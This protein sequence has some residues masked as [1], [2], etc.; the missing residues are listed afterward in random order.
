MINV[1]NGLARCHE[2]G[3]ASFTVAEMMRT[4]DF[5]LSTGYKE[6]DTVANGRLYYQESLKYYLMPMVVYKNSY[7]YACSNVEDQVLL[8]I[9]A[10]GGDD[11]AIRS[12]CSEE[13]T[14]SGPNPNPAK[15]CPGRQ[16][17]QI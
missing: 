7:H 11:K 13:S 12:W 1:Q 10:L 6:S 5:I 16:K 3:V 4:G 14:I 15:S 9:V 17:P 8:L 2:P